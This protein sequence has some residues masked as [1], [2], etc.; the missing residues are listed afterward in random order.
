MENISDQSAQQPP[1]ACQEGTAND[2][3]TT[4]NEPGKQCH[5]RLRHRELRGHRAQPLPRLIE[6]QR[7]NRRAIH[8][9]PPAIRNTTIPL[10]SDAPGGSTN[11]PT[12][13][14][15]DQISS[16]TPPSTRIPLSPI[17][18][19]PTASRI[20]P[21]R[22]SRASASSRA[23]KA[24]TSSARRDSGY[25]RPTN[26]LISNPMPNAIS[27]L[28]KGRSSMRCPTP[29]TERRTRAGSTIPAI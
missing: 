2:R 4:E 24:M 29:A 11:R 20:A 18:T 17:S 22:N 27:M 10:I 12:N 13:R 25:L 19:T 1:A 6:R 16:T 3:T 7:F 8:N 26:R 15:R 28:S 9:N 21:R 5:R 14:W 23:S